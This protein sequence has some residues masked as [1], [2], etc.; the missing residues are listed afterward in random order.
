MLTSKYFI[1][2][3]YLDVKKKHTEWLK[4]MSHV[5]AQE[6]KLDAKFHTKLGNCQSE[7]TRETIDH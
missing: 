3:N 6:D 7:V 2:K 4:N 5:A 1:V